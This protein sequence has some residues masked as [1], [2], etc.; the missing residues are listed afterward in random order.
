MWPA[1]GIA[2]EIFAKKILLKCITGLLSL[3][4]GRILFD[5]LN[6]S[7][8]K[9]KDLAGEGLTV[10]MTSH[11]LDHAFMISD[12]V[13]IQKVSDHDQY[14][15]RFQALPTFEPCLWGRSPKGEAPNPGP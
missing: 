12:K 5:G 4:S 14:S 1:A 6:I 8:I 10:M 7:E 3:T 9:R 13:V 2:I 11:N 15:D